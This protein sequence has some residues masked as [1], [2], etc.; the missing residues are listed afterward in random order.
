MCIGFS[1]ERGLRLD[2][3]PKH[4]EI[5]EHALKLALEMGYKVKDEKKDSRVA[6]IS[7]K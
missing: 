6:L 4:E 3:M 5:M 7:K 1:R 2:N